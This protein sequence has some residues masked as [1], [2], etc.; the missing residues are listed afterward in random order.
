M[1]PIQTILH[2]TDFS[3]HA[4]YAF[5]LATVIARD[6]GARLILLHVAGAHVN[7]PQPIHTEI[8]LAF[9]C[10]GDDRSRHE[11]L[12]AKLHERF[13]SNPGVRVEP[14]LLYGPA[15]IEILHTAEDERCD[16][17]IMGTQ[18]RS[19]LGRLLMGSVAE[20]VLRK[21]TCPVIVVRS[22]VAPAV[23]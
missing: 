22:P 16:M 3:T 2:P 7:L 21:A 12:E 4:D 19:G 11:A 9:D 14:R 1:L 10:S 13:D 20:E 17:I 6:C 15:A 18:G 8:G 23:G 5:R